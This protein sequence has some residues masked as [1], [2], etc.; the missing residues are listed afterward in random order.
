MSFTTEQIRTL[1]VAGH[2]QTGKTTLVEHLLQ[3][4]G[5]IPKAET[6]ESGKTVSDFTPEEIE[7][8][9]SIRAA[10][11]NLEWQGK[12]LNFWDTPGSSDFTGEVTAAFRAS[13]TA[14]MLVDARSGVQIETIKLWRNLD[15]AGKP[16]MVFINKLDG[17]RADFDACIQGLREQFKTEICP[18]SIPIGQGAQYKGCVDLLHG[19]AYDENGAETAVPDSMADT[20]KRAKEVLAGAAAEGDDDLLVKFIDEAGLSDEDII[21]GLKLAMAAGA[22]VPVFAGSAAQNS[23]C[24]PLLDFIAEIL[25]SPE[26]A[27]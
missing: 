9:I 11:A 3:T 8:K 10:L 21:R 20:V 17:E 13:E 5:V 4:A 25:P 12:N 27:A 14:L 24:V 16:R 1:A 23:G 7:R 26:G 2:G 19:K 6:V 22:I 15:A 18:V